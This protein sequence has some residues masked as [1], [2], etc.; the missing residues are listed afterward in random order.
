MG[1]ATFIACAT[2]FRVQTD[3]PELTDGKGVERLGL[4]LDAGRVQNRAPMAAHDAAELSPDEFAPMR[5][6][7]AFRPRGQRDRPRV[8]AEV[9]SRINPEV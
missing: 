3:A 6:A 8:A 2:R 5:D 9:I 4:V 7:P 1:C